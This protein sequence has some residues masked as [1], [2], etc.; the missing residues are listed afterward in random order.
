MSQATLQFQC[1]IKFIMIKSDIIRYPLCHIPSCHHSSHALYFQSFISMTIY[2]DN[3]EGKELMFACNDK[4]YHMSISRMSN[5]G[6]L[7]YEIVVIVSNFF[8][9]LYLVLGTWL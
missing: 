7:H 1:I 9:L 8:S 5:Y 3:G 2:L 4:R 6:V